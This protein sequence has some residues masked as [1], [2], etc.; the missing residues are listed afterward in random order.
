[1]GSASV[2]TGGEIGTLWVKHDATC[3]HY[4]NQHNR[5][6]DTIQGHWLSTGDKYRQDAEGYFWYAGRS[7]DMLKASGVWVSPIEVEAVLTEHDLVAEAAV[8]GRKDKDSLVKPVA[9]VVLRDNLTGTP[10]LARALQ[11]FVVSRLPIYKRPRWI[12]FTPSLPKTAT[13]KIQR[14]RLRE[15]FLA[16]RTQARIDSVDALAADSVPGDHR[17]SLHQFAENSSLPEDQSKTKSN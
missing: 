14:F 7:D 15:K 11:E 12:E 1:M 8:V 13:G 4:W 10:E 5:T 6:K 16:A 2:V 17:Q 3:S 9:W